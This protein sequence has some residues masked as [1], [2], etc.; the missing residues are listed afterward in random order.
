MP[1]DCELGSVVGG[2]A[3]NACEGPVGIAGYGGGGG[4]VGGGAGGG[5]G[6]GCGAVDGGGIPMGT[7]E[8]KGEIESCAKG[9]GPNDSCGSYS[10]AEGGAEID[11]LESATE[12]IFSS[13]CVGG[14]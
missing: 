11:K 1:I 14:G 7:S 10:R 3:A 2:K 13:I 4:R 9:D 6:I 8:L 5:W 12:Y